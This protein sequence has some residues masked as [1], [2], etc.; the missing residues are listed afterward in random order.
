MQAP[1]YR[2]NV[3]AILRQD[4]GEILI[5]KRTDQVNCWQFPQGG[6]KPGETLEDA[7]RRELEE[8]ISLR[9]AIAGERVPTDTS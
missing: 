7:L 9:R 8:E 5:G 4:T 2:S 6:V 1:R 3:A